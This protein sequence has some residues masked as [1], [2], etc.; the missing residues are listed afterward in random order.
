MQIHIIK[1]PASASLSMQAKY[2]LHNSFHLYTL[3]EA[4]KENLVVGFINPDWVL[5]D[6]SIDHAIKMIEKG[7]RLVLIPDLVV[8]TKSFLPAL[9]D[10]LAGQSLHGLGISSRSLVSMALTALHQRTKVDFVDASPYNKSP[11]RFFWHVGGRGVLER[12][13]HIHPLLVW[14]MKKGCSFSDSVGHDFIA[15]AVPDFEK[16]YIAD[17]S[18]KIFHVNIQ[19]EQDALQVMP[20]FERK[21]VSEWV[22]HPSN[23]YLTSLLC[24]T[25]KIHT[26]VCEGEEWDSVEKESEAFVKSITSPVEWNSGDF[27]SITESVNEVS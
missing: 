9:K 12:G 25:I 26:G 5:S 17:N 6:G 24:H 23:V 1:S 19:P 27:A 20:K 3:R 15:R 11:C 4:E 16:V 7:Y 21:D 13:F 8:E 22:N 2:D 14:P 10:F 18:D